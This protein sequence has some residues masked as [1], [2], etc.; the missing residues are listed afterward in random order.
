[1]SLEKFSLKNNRRKEKGPFDI[2]GDIHGCFD[3]LYELLHRLGYQI[4]LNIH[5]NEESFSIR[6]SENRIPV[7]LGDLVNKGPKNIRVLRFVMDLVNENMAYCV[8]GNHEKKLLYYLRGKDSRLRGG[9][10]DTIEQLSGY[11]AEFRNSVV[12]FIR[13]LSDHYVF[14]H[15]NLVV[16]HAGLREEMQ[17]RTSMGVRNFCMYGENSDDV[18]EYGMPVRY[19]WVQN[20]RGKARVVFGHTPILEPEWYNRTIDIDTGCVYGGRLTALRYPELEMVSVQARKI[21]Y[22]SR[23]PLPQHLSLQS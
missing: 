10:Q 5:G 4:R 16:A 13:R 7:F 18:D 20:Y 15:G 9:L 17:G 8:L 21:Y 6:H 22:Q 3:E 2:I 11:S 19:S 14:D 12:E 23:S 1:M